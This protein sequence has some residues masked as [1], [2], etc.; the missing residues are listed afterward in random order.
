MFGGTILAQLI[1]VAHRSAPEMSNTSSLHVFFLC[2]A[3]GGIS[4]EY[5]V[6]T[7]HDGRASATREVNV[8]QSGRTVA[9]ATIN[10]HAPRAVWSHAAK[11]QAEIT[12]DRLPPTGMPHPARAIPP[13]AVEF[14]YHDAN[15]DGTFVRYLWFRATEQVPD[16]VLD[17]ECAAALISDLY[18][19]EPVVAQQGF[20][21]ND[22]SI[23]YAT[24]QHSVWFHATP[25]VDEWTV[26]ES[27]SPV[28]AGGR[29][30]VTGEIRTLSGTMVA[31]VVQEVAVRLP[32][33]VQ[34]TP[35]L[36]SVTP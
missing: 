5:H 28:A 7:L 35:D 27:R 17:H 36:H 24:T 12:P 21:G 30:L 11:Y 1:A 2:P 6:R 9:V 18:F 3:D 25:R 34:S 26:V 23:K 13:G 32:E 15:V 29:G 4:C 20:R 10:L 33:P 22:R 8:V 16:T 31:T 14:K 19:F